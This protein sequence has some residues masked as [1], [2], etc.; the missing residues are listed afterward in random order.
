MRS[1]S[2]RPTIPTA[3]ALLAAVGV[4]IVLSA[5]VGLATLRLSGMYFVIFTFGLA[6]LVQRHRDAGGSST[7]PRRPA[8][9]CSCRSPRPHIY[10]QLL[11][12]C[13]A[14]IAAVDR[15]ATAAAWAL[16]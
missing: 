5:F 1:P 3:L 6:A 11:A 2:W 12:L 7:S 14:I 4:S 15:R 10:Y 16:P 13:V 8:G 9:T